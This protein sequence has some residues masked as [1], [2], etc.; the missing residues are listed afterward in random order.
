MNRLL[1]MAEEEEIKA[2]NVPEA[3][4][5]RIHMFMEKAETLRASYRELDELLE[6]IE[7]EI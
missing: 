3:L 2:H 7:N 5:D 4:I 1:E 6:R